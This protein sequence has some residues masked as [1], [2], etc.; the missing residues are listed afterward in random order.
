MA[1]LSPARNAA[2][3]VCRQVRQ[4]NAFASQVF[5]SIVLP[6]HLSSEDEAFARVLVM[7]VVST[8][9]S[10][11]DI[12]N[13]GLSNPDD[14]DNNVRDAL[15][16]STYEMCFLEKEPY[17]AVSQGVEL[18]RAVRPRAAK[19]ANFA[20][21]RVAENAEE[22]ITFRSQH[23]HDVKS[24]LGQSGVNTS[25][26][27]EAQHTTTDMLARSLG[28]PLWMAEKLIEQMGY[29]RALEFM[30]HSNDPA[31]LF[32]A[33]NAC[34]TSDRE[35]IEELEAAGVSMRPVRLGA[36][37]Q[38]IP[39]CVRMQHAHCIGQWPVQD[40]LASGACIVADASAQAI[41]WLSVPERA[42][43]ASFD[44]PLRFLEIGAGRGT[45]TVLIQSHARR[46]W[47]IPFD[48]TCVDKHG[49]KANVLQKRVEDLHVP[50]Q[51]IVQADAT[52]LHDALEGQ[53][54]DACL[55]D[56]PCSGV[57]TLRRHPEIRW[58]LCPDEIKTLASL[59]LD[60]L[61]EASRYIA[62]G[63]RLI[64]S[65]CT[66]FSEE[67]ELVVKAFLESEEGQAFDIV[68][69]EIGG[70]KRLTFSTSLGPASPDAHFACVFTKRT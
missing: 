21:H 13:A 67:N 17:V 49:F 46:A 22:L 37:D 20:L 30:K 45:K 69:L 64:Y 59:G 63:G 60:M 52:D 32:I 18:V 19:L 68:P 62:P 27:M 14:I 4:R 41:A 9:G 38:P 29:I 6:L 48:L 25:A 66:V 47:G 3:Q 34:Y 5:D 50:V 53:F 11:D 54:F 56:A 7:G 42:D 58:N 36:D 35:S 39:G 16:I 15:R 55:V 23:V 43:S 31:P 44:Q 10:L 61:K 65:T 57:G 70:G 12:I 40:M 8:W 24:T 26:D 33:L 28:F 51:A 2:L 1:K